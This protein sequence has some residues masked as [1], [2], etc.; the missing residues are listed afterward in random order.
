M[1]QANA[2]TM[3][4]RRASTALGDLLSSVPDAS[5]GD[6]G[7]TAVA[8]LAEVHE[9]T[10][11]VPTGGARTNRAWLEQIPGVAVDRVMTVL[12]CRTMCMPRRHERNDWTQ[13]HFLAD[14]ASIT[15]IP[16]IVKPSYPGASDACRL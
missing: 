15:C 11:A 5:L 2:K 8:L 16:P 7:S 14:Q 12:G 9:M 4:S 10:A 3:V 6:A 13:C 1:E